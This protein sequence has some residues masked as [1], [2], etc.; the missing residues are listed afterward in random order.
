[1]VAET[2][3]VVQ[4]YMIDGSPAWHIYRACPLSADLPAASFQ[5]QAEAP[6]PTVCPLTG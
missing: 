5:A 1:M 4:H 6:K 2:A 3:D